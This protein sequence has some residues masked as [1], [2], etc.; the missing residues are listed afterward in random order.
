MIGIP[1]QGEHHAARVRKALDGMGYRVY[2][3]LMHGRNLVAEKIDLISEEHY[4]T[5]DRAFIDEVDMITCRTRLPGENGD[6]VMVWV[7][8]NYVEEPKE[9]Y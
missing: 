6:T 1:C 4:T 9:F 2:M 3:L 7:D 5:R 8:I